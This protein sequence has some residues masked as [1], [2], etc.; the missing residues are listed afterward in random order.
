M[1]KALNTIILIIIFVQAIC[2][3]AKSSFSTSDPQFYL[4][5]SKRPVNSI[6]G[7]YFVAQVTGMS[8]I[9]R[10]AA[11]VREI[12]SG[13]VPSFSRKL[14]AIKLSQTVDAENYE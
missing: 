4:N 8:T 5:I 14:R 7:S 10:E 2:A 1:V 6:E 9:D 13:N 11:V 12:L 3:Q